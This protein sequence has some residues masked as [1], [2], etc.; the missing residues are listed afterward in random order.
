MLAHKSLLS[1]TTQWAT[2]M[3]SPS[4][5][6]ASRPR[7]PAKIS[8]V[9]AP[10]RPALKHQNKIHTMPPEKMEIFKSLDGWAKDQ[11]LPLLK[12]V[13]QCW[14][15]ASFLPDPALPFSEFTDQVRYIHHESCYSLIYEEVEV[16][17]KFITLS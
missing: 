5:F 16:I 13:D 4:T 3:P 11:I 15:P 2:L 14:Q 6:L 9:A 12:P 1:F 7:G 8:A 10:V 17:T